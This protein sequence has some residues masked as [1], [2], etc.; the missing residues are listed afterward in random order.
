[1][2]LRDLF[3]RNHRK[4]NRIEPTLSSSSHTERHN[5]TVDF[6]AMSI[7]DIVGWVSALPP[8]ITFQ[9]IKGG[10]LRLYDIAFFDHGVEEQDREKAKRLIT[11]I[12]QTVENGLAS[13]PTA[14]AA[15]KTATDFNEKRIAMQ[16][17]NSLAWLLDE[18]HIPGAD[19]IPFIM[20]PEHGAKLECFLDLLEPKIVQDSKPHMV[21]ELVV[22][23]HGRAYH[24]TVLH[25]HGLLCRGDP[26]ALAV[27]SIDEIEALIQTP[28]DYA[29]ARRVLASL[30]LLVAE[31][32]ALG[33][34]PPPTDDLLRIIVRQTAID[35]V[36]ERPP[37]PIEQVNPPASME[38]LDTVILIAL[39]I[40]LGLTMIEA[41]YGVDKGILVLDGIEDQFRAAEEHGLMKLVGLMRNFEKLGLERLTAEIKASG[42]TFSIDQMMVF[43]AWQEFNLWPTEETE[44]LAVQPYLAYLQEKISFIRI[45]YLIRLRSYLRYFI[46][47]HD[48]TWTSSSAVAAEIRNAIS[49]LYVH[50]GSRDGIA[51]AAAFAEDWIGISS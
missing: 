51:E 39:C 28:H 7:N 25:L 1:M 19:T 35:T 21:R 20:K 12:K 37:E 13:D 18:Q 30:G 24:N 11:A 38:G 31:S 14:L 23:R 32:S 4:P 41:L 29:A 43:A 22:Q 6:N 48:A 16:G 50:Y 45:D 46:H 15:F 5:L 10:L 26:A 49:D 8:S 9:A 17:V 3:R 40:H 44:W 36:S 27:F 42:P 2:S 33:L 47:R 34:H